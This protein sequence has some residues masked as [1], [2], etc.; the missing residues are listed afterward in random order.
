[1]DSVTT[2]SSSSGQIISSRLVNKFGGRTS[3]SGGSGGGGSSH[4]TQQQSSSS[5]NPFAIQELLGL[6]NNSD[7]EQSNKPPVN[8]SVSVND[9]PKLNSSWNFYH[10]HQQPQP[11]QPTSNFQHTNN[12]QLRFNHHPHHG[13]RFHANGMVC[14]PNRKS[15][16]VRHIIAWKWSV[17]SS[18][19]SPGRKK[20]TRTTLITDT[21]SG[22]QAWESSPHS[23]A[24]SHRITTISIIHSIHFTLI[25]FIM[26]FSYSFGTWFTREATIFKELLVSAF[27]TSIKAS[28]V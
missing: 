25:K 8:N 6:N 3:G 15:K 5:A 16:S 23:L 27:R 18:D 19:N 4:S 28:E 9:D 7:N 22:E 21:L 12:N 24:L 26:A 2:S 17:R 10:H 11:Q 13:S 1:M 14:F 20:C